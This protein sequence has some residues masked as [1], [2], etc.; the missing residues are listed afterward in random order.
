MGPSCPK[1]T[2]KRHLRSYLQRSVSAAPLL[3][4]SVG[5]KPNTWKSWDLESFETPE[6]LELDSKGKNTRIE[7]FLV[8]LERSWNVDIE[9][10]LA[11]AIRTSAAPV[12]GKR[13]AG[14]QTDV[15][16]GS[17]I[18][19]WKDL[20]EGYNFGLDLVAIELYS[21]ELWRFKVPG[22]PSG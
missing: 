8:S 5:V 21:R 17:A 14:S 19:H 1:A 20:D 10:A 3:C 18:G 11:L 13:R 6:C 4:P 12:M 15:R 16:F 7:V 2:Q 22:V 9:N